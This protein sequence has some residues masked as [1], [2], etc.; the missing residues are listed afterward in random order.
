M[1]GES[2]TTGKMIAGACNF[3]F[4]GLAITGLY[5]WWPRKWNWRALKPSVWFVG[6]KGKARDW[7]WHNVIGL[8]SA[9]VLIVLTATALPISYSWVTGLISRLDD[10]QAPVPEAAPR[11]ST[12][13][14]GTER[15]NI[16]TLLAAVQHEI[17]DWKQIT[18]RLDGGAGGRGGGRGGSPA[19]GPRFG[20]ASEPA[21]KRQ[22]ASRG[23]SPITATVR[24]HGSWPRTSNTT[25]SLNPFTG[26][27]LGR[28]GYADLTP[29]RQ[30]R[31][32]TRF[33]HTGEALGPAGQFFAGLASLAGCFLV[34]T[35]FALSWRRF[36]RKRSRP[37]AAVVYV[38][39]V[40]VQDAVEVPSSG[41]KS[42]GN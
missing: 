33:L 31:A 24:E 8:W 16:Q 27:T 18:L 4:L 36:F 2:R 17:P 9:P 19:G 25:L 39:E 37:V 34:W 23:V 13:A 11:A 40:E 35:G 20:N 29:S 14:P 22:T 41:P 38:R 1:S 3:A 12:P 6:S 30:V 15:A 42:S 7:N 5:I 28:E 21:A 26:S 10:T 32:W